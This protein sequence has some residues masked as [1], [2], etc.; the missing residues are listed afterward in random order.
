M[1]ILTRQI[2]QHVGWQRHVGVAQI[3][4]ELVIELVNG[5]LHARSVPDKALLQ[6][7]STSVRWS[8]W[9]DVCLYDTSMHDKRAW[10]QEPELNNRAT[11]ATDITVLR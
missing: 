4:A 6:A 7:T 5:T 11:T 2:T 1:E 10:A 3:V 9:F 8:T